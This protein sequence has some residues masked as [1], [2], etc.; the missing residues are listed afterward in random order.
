MTT[1]R[2]SW[3]GSVSFGLVNFNVR[4]YGAATSRDVSFNQVHASCNSRIKS[5]IWCPSCE[6][7]V[8]RTELIKGYTVSKEQLVVLD[9]QD[10][11]Q[12][13]LN[14][15]KVVEIVAVVPAA[16]VPTQMVEKSYWVGPDDRTKVGHKPFALL[17]DVLAAKNVVAIGRIAMRSGKEN[18]V[19]LRP[20]GKALEMTILYWADELVDSGAVEETVSDVEISPAER[21]LAE[22]L[23]ASLEQPIDVVFEQRDAYRDAVEALVE[24]KLQGKEPLRAPEMPKVESVDLMAALEASIR[25]RKAA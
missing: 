20:H 21:S 22:T 14:S 1:A 12:L 10:M 11:A 16:D 17:R 25:A 8:E 23:V 6:R 5:P 7:M 3:S 9:E 2:A 19:A 24:A 4:L 13:P 18:L 15:T